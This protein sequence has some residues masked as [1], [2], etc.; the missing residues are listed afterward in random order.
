MRNTW[1]VYLCDD[2]EGPITEQRYLTAVE[3]IIRG[4]TFS[5][6]GRRNPDGAMMEAA[7]RRIRCMAL[8]CRHELYCRRDPIPQWLIDQC[9][10]HHDG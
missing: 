3:R 6:S 1:N 5:F 4:Y 9:G 2:D 8:A 10:D 7:R